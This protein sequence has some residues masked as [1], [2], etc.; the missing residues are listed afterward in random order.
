MILEIL[1]VKRKEVEKLF[2]FTRR[3][4]K[5][6]DLGDMDD[7]ENNEDLN[8]FITSYFDT[9]TKHLMQGFELMASQFGS[10]TVPRISSS[11][12]HVEGKTNGETIFLKTRPHNRPHEFKNQ[13]GP[14]IP[15]FLESK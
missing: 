3:L 10:K 4:R 7:K 14:E 2:L 9:M 6:L 12:P 1:R 8:T 13:S 5:K 11:A 15:N